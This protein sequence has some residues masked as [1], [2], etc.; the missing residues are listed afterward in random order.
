[1]STNEELP[2]EPGWYLAYDKLA[3]KPFTVEASDGALWFGF[4]QQRKLGDPER[5]APFIRL[6]PT[7]P[8]V[9]EPDASARWDE[10]IDVLLN[11]RWVDPEAKVAV[12][13]YHD[14]EISKAELKRRLL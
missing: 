7:P 8:V 11:G 2:T 1:M 4:P 3:E 6:V 14:G 10:A 9:G 12:F 13:A 5:F